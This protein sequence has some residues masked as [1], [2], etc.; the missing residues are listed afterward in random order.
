MAASAGGAEQAVA[1]GGGGLTR[2][3]RRSLVLPLP[4]LLAVRQV[5]FVSTVRLLALVDQGGL[6]VPAG[7][8]LLLVQRADFALQSA[9]RRSTLRW[10]GQ[11]VVEQFGIR[12]R[13]AL[14]VVAHHILHREYK[15]TEPRAV[16]GPGWSRKP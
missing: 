3:L 16:A 5:G 2:T 7:R 9:S 4:A 13:I 14:P 15:R 1:A 8:S 12:V 6:R 11:I 10:R